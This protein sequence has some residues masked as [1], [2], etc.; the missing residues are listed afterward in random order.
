MKQYLIDIKI[1]FHVKNNARYIVVTLQFFEKVAGRDRIFKNSTRSGLDNLFSE[2]VRF[3]RR[4]I[5]FL[6]DRII[7]QQLLVGKG[8]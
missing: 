5:T 3:E 7:T 4:T 8:I 1:I 6:S 2:I